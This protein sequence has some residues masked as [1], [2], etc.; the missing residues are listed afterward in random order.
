MHKTKIFIGQLDP[1]LWCSYYLEALNI[2][3]VGYNR[4]DICMDL[5]GFVSLDVFF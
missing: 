5:I 2:D 3:I 4:D 1:L